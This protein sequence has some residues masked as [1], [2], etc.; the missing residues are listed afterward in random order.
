MKHSFSHRDS[1]ARAYIELG[2]QNGVQSSRVLV[3]G[4][5]TAGFVLAV[6]PI[7]T[8]SVIT[9][10]SIG[11]FASEISIPTTYGSIPVYYARPAGEGVY[12]VVLVIQEIFEVH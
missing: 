8:Q 9:T 6:Q 10:D 11:L 4:L 1:D 2:S 12:P 3:G 7:Q 5:A